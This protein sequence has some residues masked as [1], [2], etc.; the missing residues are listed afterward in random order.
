MAVNPGSPAFAMPPQ[1]DDEQR[2]QRDLERATR[3]NAAARG[4]AASQIGNGGTLRIDGS[5][6]VTGSITVPGTLTSAG[7]LSAGTTVT[8]GTSVTAPQGTFST[9]VTAPQGTFSSGLSSV[10][11][12]NTDVS[13]IA[14]ARQQVWQHNTGVYG[15]APSSLTTKTNLGSIPFTAADVL[16][17]QPYVFQYRGQIAIR[18]D[19]ENAQHDPDYTVPWEIGLMAEHLI[20]NSMGCFVFWE[21]DGVTPK[22]INYDLFG[23]IAPLVV[24]ADQERRLNAAGL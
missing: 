18:D 24:L 13:L 4:L 8:A 20:A 16:A 23:A 3:E 12:Y 19:P 15:F 11:A 14:G 17:V 6:Q 9:S 22:G 7:A 21:D 10:G 5:L 2:A 1:E